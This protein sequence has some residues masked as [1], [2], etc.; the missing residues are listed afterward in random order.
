[1]QNWQRPIKIHCFLDN[2]FAFRTLLKAW[3][4][5]EN[6][7]NFSLKAKIERYSRRK[8]KP[9]TYI[10]VLNISQWRNILSC[11]AKPWSFCAENIKSASERPVWLV[12][13]FSCNVFVQVD[14]EK[15]WSIYLWSK[16][17]MFSF[18]GKSKI[19]S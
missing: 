12:M 9:R 15:I 4:Q 10:N 6:F 14:D 1:M 5:Q 13:R 8:S 19:D 17:H 7:H 11:I 18:S 16:R 3:L 2:K